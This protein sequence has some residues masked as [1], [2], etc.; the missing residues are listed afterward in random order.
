MNKTEYIQVAVVTES[1]DMTSDTTFD[2]GTDNSVTYTENQQIPM[3]SQILQT[4]PLS[5]EEIRAMIQQQ[6][7]SQVTS[8]VKDAT[9]IPGLNII[10][11]VIAII[12]M[13]LMFAT[14][15]SK[16]ADINRVSK[17]NSDLANR[18]KELEQKLETQEKNFKRELSQKLEKQ[19]LKIEL[20]RINQ[21]I[22]NLKRPMTSPIS[23]I[24]P[25]PISQNVARTIPVTSAI[26]P[27]LS[28]IM[29]G[30]SATF[31]NE[32]NN[33]FATDASEYRNARDT[34]IHNYKLKG[35]KCR[36]YTELTN[37]PDIDP[38][39]ESPADS[40]IS[41]SDYFAFE[42]DSDTFA[43]VPNIRNY[44]ENDH[45]SKAM[46]KVFKSN[47][48]GSVCNKIRVIK[49]AI[50]KGKWNLIERGEL[51]LG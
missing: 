31:I 8:K 37:N 40:Q 4:T 50:F 38:E 43:V 10:S 48:N 24:N 28:Q 3:D 22:N 42:F 17:V 29:M 21:E 7:D 6:V 5:R 16:A 18:V 46:S 34:L 1:S 32:C 30:K 2:R 11:L 47:F 12:A 35:L 14:L 39:F 13:V 9:E 49:P 33:L 45:T 36:N 15:R 19:D 25:Q 27:S 26:T 41:T 44:T 20:N 51:E 23:S